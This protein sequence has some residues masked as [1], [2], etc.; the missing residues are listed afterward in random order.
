[1]FCITK[2]LRGYGFVCQMLQL[3]FITIQ[4][5]KFMRD[6]DLLNNIFFWFSMIWGLSMVRLP[7]SLLYGELDANEGVG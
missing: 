2:K 6:K 7:Y 1:M 5:S 3:P 4:R